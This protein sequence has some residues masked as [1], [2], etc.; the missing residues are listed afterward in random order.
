MGEP[1]EISG[2]SDIQDGVDHHTVMSLKY[3]NGAIAQLS[4]AIKLEKPYDAYLYGTEGQIYVPDFY[5]ASEYEITYKDGTKVKREYPYGDNGFE[6]EIEEA[7]KC[8]TEGKTESNLVPLA[9]TIKTLEIMDE[10]RRITG[11]IYG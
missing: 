7:C 9:N 1:E 6:F 4:S 11:I 3:K 8:I 5:K 2:F 10:I